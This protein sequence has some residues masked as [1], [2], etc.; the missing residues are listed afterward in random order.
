MHVQR[1]VY[2]VERWSTFEIHVVSTFSDNRRLST[3]VSDVFQRF[4]T[5]VRPIYIFN[6][7]ATFFQRDSLTLCQR[8][9]NVFLLAGVIIEDS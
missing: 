8:C 2:L 5:Y 1:F 3:L 7:F 6:T 9:I 4:I